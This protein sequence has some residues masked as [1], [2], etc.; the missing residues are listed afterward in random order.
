MVRTQRIAFLSDGSDYSS[1]LVAELRESEADVRE[2]ERSDELSEFLDDTYSAVVIVSPHVHQARAARNSM[3][4]IGGRAS[5]VPLI[6]ALRDIELSAETETLRFFDD[7]MVQPGGASELL[8]RV[9]VL[10]VRRGKQG[11]LIEVGDLV[12]NLDAHQVIC[13]GMLVDLTYK[14]FELLKMLA[15]TPGRAYTRDELLKSVWGYDY[16]GGTRTVD[17]HVRRLRSKIE[18]TTQ[19][20]E[21]VHGVGY[22]FIAT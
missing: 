16:Y 7:F 17:V 3:R 15:S 2:F 22:R 1:G 19:Y 10:M 12:V 21:T 5:S 14:E 18:S 4:S 6:A 20:I 13:G 11:N 9:R 8:A